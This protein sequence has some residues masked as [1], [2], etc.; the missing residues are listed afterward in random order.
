MN[1]DNEI[2][3]QLD[4]ELHIRSILKQHLEKYKSNI[5]KAIQWLEWNDKLL[6]QE[7]IEQVLNYFNGNIC[8]DDVY[9]FLENNIDYEILW[10]ELIAE[11]TN[12]GTEQIIVIANHPYTSQELWIDTASIENKVR[13]E[14]MYSTLHTP[15]VRSF[16]REKLMWHIPYKT[17]ITP[18]GYTKAQRDMNNIEMPGKDNYS[19]VKDYLEWHENESAFFFPEWGYTAWSTFRTGFLHL[20]KELGIKK[21]VTVATNDYISLFHKNKLHVINSHCFE[22]FESLE[23]VEQA[24][25]LI[26]DEIFEY[27]NQKL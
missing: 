16:L 9:S 19:F 3:R 13:G 10:S 12:N 27:K 20:A 4:D 26:R 24:K 17:F 11:A 14:A 1:S 8:L 21:F 23:S 18:I 15:I 2:N 6:Y 25:R 5:K 7:Y 22:D